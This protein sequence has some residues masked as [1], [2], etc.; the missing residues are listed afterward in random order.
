MPVIVDDFEGRIR[1]QARE[2]I[3]TSEAD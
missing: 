2:V 1:E 3:D